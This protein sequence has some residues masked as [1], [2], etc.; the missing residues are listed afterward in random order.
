MKT[1]KTA[2]VSEKK[3]RRKF[4]DTFKR[5]AVTL[6]IN[7]GKSAAQVAADLGIAENRLYSWKK[8]FA[9][10]AAF[11]PGQVETEL[12]A[13][14]RENAYLREQRDILKKTL[15]ILSEPPRSASHGSMR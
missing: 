13:L 6:W 3:S 11:S 8:Q 5:D 10:S 9:P 7:S 2:E 1:V 4:D 15:G 12:V 14:R